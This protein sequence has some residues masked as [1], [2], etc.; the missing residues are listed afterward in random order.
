MELVRAERQAVP[1][2]LLEVPSDYRQVDFMML[3]MTPEQEQKWKE[4][5]QKMQEMLQK[6]P[7][8][9]RKKM[10]EMMRRQGGGG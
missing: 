8:E 3:N 7:P 6:L 5:Q 10:E 9:Q 1:A 4:S 2:S